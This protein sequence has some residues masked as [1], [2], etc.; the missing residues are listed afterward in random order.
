VGHTLASPVIDTD[1][2]THKNTQKFRSGKTMVHNRF[3]ISDTPSLIFSKEETGLYSFQVN[4]F[5][6]ELTLN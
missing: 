3:C 5:K 6:E 4:D 1:F 2:S